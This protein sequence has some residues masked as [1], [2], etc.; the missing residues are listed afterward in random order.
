[1]E[2]IVTGDFTKSK[3]SA[4]LARIRLR[5]VD[6]A[7]I[8][9]AAAMGRTVLLTMAAVAAVFRKAR[10]GSGAEKEEFSIGVGGEIQSRR[11]RSAK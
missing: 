11:E 3:A 1:M 9:G 2:A 10:R 4:G 8:A 6:E 5:S 7:L